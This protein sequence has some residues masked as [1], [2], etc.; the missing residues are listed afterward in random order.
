MAAPG[1]DLA[2]EAGKGLKLRPLLGLAG[3]LLAALTAEFND[4][5]TST[6]L[7]DVRGGLGISEDPGTW[8]SSLFATG[9]VV[10]MSMATFW[11]LTVS[12]RHWL[13]FVVAATCV[14][15]VCIPFTSNLG[16]L[17]G[18]R[19]V[20]G[21][22]SGF[23]IPLL[24]TVA[25][26]VLPPPVR[27][28]GLA[29]YGLTATFGPNIST[30][31]AALW[32]ELVGWRFV[33]F[34]G[35]PLCAL[36]GLLIWHGVA[37]QP[38]KYERIRQFDWRGAL[39]VLIGFGAFTTMLEQGNR[40]DWFNSK[41]ICVLALVSAV[42]LPLLVLNDLMVELPLYRF[43]LLRRRNFL[44]GLTTLFT[45]LLLSQS[46]STIPLQYLQQVAGFRPEQSYVVT[47]LIAVPQ[48]LLLPAIAFLLDFE[49]VD[50]RWVLFAGI[51]CVITACVGNSFLTSV[52][53]ARTFLF[54][55]VF[56]VFGAPLVVMPL[57]MMSVNT[58]KD[59]A[60]GPFASTL[61]NTM[62][63]AAEPVGVWMLQLIMHWRGGLHYNRIVDQSGQGSFSALQQHD[64]G[65]LAAFRDAVQ[66]QA[67]VLT[68]SDAFLVIACLAVVL[69]A[70]LAVLPVRTYPPRIV[71]QQP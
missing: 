66:A 24:L 13:L 63:G 19:F 58:I 64:A 23:T 51:V 21:L 17:Y 45:F 2:S 56:Q 26:Q 18:L 20:Q 16:L 43:S 14:S 37:Q 30:A 68:L 27:L 67:T 46:A 9:Q 69:M 38:P 54:W 55:Q 42:A 47:V 41:P 22:C 40:L 25:L 28:Y 34:E 31:L 29:A 7:T 39:L 50:A 8:F 5:V 59:P 15:T 70:V 1:Q 32:T 49:R 6:A 71:A 57:L 60:D 62:R 44:F 4:G 36:S 33:F 52:W 35:L 53:D 65:S 48:F 10:G 61:V 11:A 12:I 3:V